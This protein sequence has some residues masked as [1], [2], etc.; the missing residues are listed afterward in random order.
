MIK[1]PEDERPV[2]AVPDSRRQEHDELVQG[3]P[4]PSLAVASERDVEVFLEPRRKR[5]VPPSPELPDRRRD[6]RI[7]EVLLEMEPEHEPQSDRHVRI[8][9]EVEIDLQHVSD[10]ADPGAKAPDLRLR[11]IKK[12]V[13]YH[14]NVVGDED[15]F[16]EAANEAPHALCGILGRLFPVRDLK[17][18]VVIFD[19]RAGDE[20][21]EKRHIQH[22]VERVFLHLAVLAVNINDV[23]HR[24]EREER[25]SDRHHE[26]RRLDSASEPPVYGPR[27][28]VRV[29]VQAQYAQILDHAECDDQL[30]K[31]R[32]PL[33]LALAYQHRPNVI[34]QA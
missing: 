26:S 24:L 7:V 15:L 34:E 29:L 20:L 21:R 11:H 32:L 9:R 33:I 22:H 2:R 28:E 18:D 17:L 31:A 3:G 13:G 27:H 6:I 25:Y 30:G 14:G 1:A 4:R 16:R 12:S 19:D 23:T 8:S 5:D 10:C